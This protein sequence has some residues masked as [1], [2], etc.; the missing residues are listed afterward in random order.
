M[1]T[2]RMDTPQE[3]LL[4]PA[5]K[6]WCLHHQRT[7]NQWVSEFT[8]PSDWFLLFY[9]H[10]FHLSDL[11]SCLHSFM[12]AVLEKMN[13]QIHIHCLKWRQLI[14]WVI[15]IIFSWSLWNCKC[16]RRL[17]SGRYKVSWGQL[18]GWLTIFTVTQMETSGDV[19]YHLG[20]CTRGHGSVHWEEAQ[21]R[22]LMSLSWK[23][24]PDKGRS[25][26]THSLSV[27]NLFWL[28]TYEEEGF[29]LLLWGPLKKRWIFGVWKS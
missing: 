6:R 16:N 24:G 23:C 17:F 10:F 28:E 20:P 13:S 3:R 14:V 5:L 22:I 29:P 7:G 4:P 2:T 21:W 27:V 8:F 9:F 25:F 1:Q 12:W 19:S 11:T 26:L 15:L 18:Q